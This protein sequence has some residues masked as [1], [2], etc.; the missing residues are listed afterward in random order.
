MPSL[1]RLNISVVQCVGFDNSTPT[2]VSLMHQPQGSKIHNMR[3]V[4]PAA[5]EPVLVPDAHFR[6]TVLR[7]IDVTERDIDSHL[8]IGH[9]AIIRL[10]IRPL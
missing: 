3:A 8:G 5:A 2:F 4:G 7:S 1:C 6:I 10:P 9:A